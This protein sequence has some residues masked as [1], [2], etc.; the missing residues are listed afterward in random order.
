MNATIAGKKDLEE[1][2]EKAKETLGGY[3][4]RKTILF[5]DEI[6]SVQ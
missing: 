4:S 5:I 2:V 1:V 3:G 6:H